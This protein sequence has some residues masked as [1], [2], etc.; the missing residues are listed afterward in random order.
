MLNK[1]SVAHNAV[2]MHWQSEPGCV[3]VAM[4]CDHT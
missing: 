4:W 2:K 3:T 1:A